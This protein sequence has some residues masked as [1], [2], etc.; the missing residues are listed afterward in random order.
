MAPGK[1]SPHCCR[2]ARARLPRVRP[3]PSTAVAV[4]YSGRGPRGRVDSRLRL[5]RSRL[6]PVGRAVPRT[7]REE[8]H[9]DS[10]DTQALSRAAAFVRLPGVDEQLHLDAQASAGAMA[11][12]RVNEDLR[13]AR[14]RAAAAQRPD[15]H[16]RDRRHVPY[17]GNADQSERR[18]AGGDFPDVQ[19]VSRGSDVGTPRERSRRHASDCPF[20]AR[21]SAGAHGNPAQI[22]GYWRVPRSRVRP[23]VLDEIFSSVAH[24]ACLGSHAVAH[25]HAAVACTGT[26]D[27]RRC[28]GGCCSAVDD[29]HCVRLS[30][31]VELR[32]AEKR[33]GGSRTHWKARAVRHGDIWR[34]CHA[35]S[36]N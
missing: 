32:S 11:S 22:R 33:C 36:A 5:G 28:R 20:R 9:T 19:W 23:G 4:F 6:A 26:R 12:S 8:S 18:A 34:R 10:T 25:G 16:G 15:L 24:A 3:G 13:R 30:A 35:T 27:C 1:R 29:L 14:I 7:R 31:R 21:H 17:R 2:R